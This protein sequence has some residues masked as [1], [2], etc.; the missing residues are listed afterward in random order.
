MLPNKERD[1]LTI[2]NR[3]SRRQKATDSNAT[4]LPAISNS[5]HPLASDVR[6]AADS[7]ET[8]LRKWMKQKMTKV[9]G[10]KNNPTQFLN[11]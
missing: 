6:V 4:R 9:K 2:Q 7:C 10:Y 11:V 8:E 5:P 1:E 3:P